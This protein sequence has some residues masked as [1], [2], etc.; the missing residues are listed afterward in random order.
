MVFSNSSR[1]ANSERE[2]K[3]QGVLH[4]SHKNEPSE[5]LLDRHRKKRFARIVEEFVQFQAIQRHLSVLD[6]TWSL[7]SD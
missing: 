1:E 3:I 2:V 6:L 7:T 5:Q 4:T